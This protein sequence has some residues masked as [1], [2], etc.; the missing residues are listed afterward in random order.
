MPYKE[1]IDQLNKNGRQRLP[2][3][4]VI[5][6]EMEQPF[7]IPLSELNQDRVRFEM[8][9]QRV[10]GREDFELSE[11]AI[12]QK[13]PLP[14]ST[15]KKAFDIVKE[16][17]NYGN[18]F[19][20]NLT[21]ETP[22]ELGVSMEEIYEKARAKY[23]LFVKDNFLCYSPETFVQITGEGKISSFPMK[24]T[25]DAK[26]PNA[27][28][29]LLNDLKEKYE[30][31]TIVDLIRNDLSKV[32]NKVWVERFRYVEKITKDDGREL[33]QVSSEICGQLPEDWRDNIGGVLNE[34][35]PAGSISGA[36]KDKTVNIIQEAEKL[37]YENGKRGFYTGIFGLF[38]GESLNSAVMIRFIEKR[39][40]Q[41][42]F[43]SGGG[44][45]TRSDARKEYQ[46]LADKIYLPL[47]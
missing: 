30:H 25:I 7:V 13:S 40:G 17:L 15:Y 24:G 28:S 10:A 44:I 29:L 16:N 4:F 8:E 39:N 37:T 26:L 27:E 42:Y 33:L 11:V 2:F 3:L 9:P 34:L 12:L 32:C 46:E 18:S 36:P 45:T 20:T 47:G 6:F 19:L 1:F 22:I 23:K 35:L 5:D 21:A 31:T 41:F 43:K 38:D 14:F